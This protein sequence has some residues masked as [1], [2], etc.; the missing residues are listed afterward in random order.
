MIGQR[1]DHR[2]EE[3]LGD[4]SSNNRSVGVEERVDQ[5]GAGAQ[6]AKAKDENEGSKK[7]IK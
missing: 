7:K 2:G 6:G 4:V 1:L 3:P 5:D